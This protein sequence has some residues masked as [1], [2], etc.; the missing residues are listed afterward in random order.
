MTINTLDKKDSKPKGGFRGMVMGTVA[1]LAAATMMFG[2]GDQDTAFADGHDSSQP[3]APAVEGGSGAFE[4]EAKVQANKK[5]DGDAKLK[6]APA[7][8]KPVPGQY[9]VTLKAGENPRS[10]MAVAKVSP[11][12]VYESA[13]NGFTAELSHGQLNALLH[14]KAVESIEPDLEIEADGHFTTQTIDASGQPYGLD[15]VDQR[16]GL[17]KSYT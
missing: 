14:H 3:P 8:S 6:T 12:W 2:F 16:S 5:V 11:K 15:R 4:N 17:S 7:G 9:I 13:L 10:V 1:A